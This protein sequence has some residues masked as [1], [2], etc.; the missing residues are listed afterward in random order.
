MIKP[1]I[2]VRAGSASM[3]RFGGTSRAYDASSNDSQELGGWHPSLS[4]VNDEVGGARDRVTARV[5]DL[6]RNDPSAFGGV[7][8]NV[9]ATVGTEMWVSSRVNWRALGLT[10]QQGAELSRQMEQRFTEWSSDPWFFCDVEGELDFGGLI[11]LA[12]THVAREDEAVAVIYGTEPSGLQKFGTQLLVMDPDQL[13]NPPSEPEQAYLRAGVET[14]RY[15]R[16]VAYWF[17]QQHP[18]ASIVDQRKMARWTRVARY[19]R[20]GRPQVVHYFGKRRAGLKRGISKLAAGLRDFK[21]LSR[22]NQAELNAQLLSAMLPLFIT[23]KNPAAIAEALAPAGDDNAQS[24]MDLRADYHEA[25][26]INFNG[27][28]IPALFDNES[29]EAVDTKRSAA[30]FSAFQAASLRRLAPL[31]GLTYEQ[32]SNDWA[33]VNYSSARAALIEIWRT[34]DANRKR[35]TRRFCTPIYQAVIWEAVVRGMI[36]LPPGAPDFVTNLA[37][38][39][40]CRWIGPGRGWVDPVKEATGAQMRTAAY[41][42]DLETEAAEQG[43]DVFENMENMARIMEEAKRLGV[44]VPG[45]PAPTGPA[46]QQDDTE[47]PPTRQRQRA[48]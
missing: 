42:T 20:T 2:R 25:S 8:K 37:H 36:T 21:Q 22:Y 48:A 3:A 16:P 24:N 19:T 46:A 47:E 32:L 35:F 34:I 39:T 10:Q 28:R 12:Y 13:C 4:E 23:S 43:E 27:V 26:N 11:E 15:G 44:P 17:Q 30:D 5:R 18:N 6:E 29:I 31:F 1:R 41:L 33:N 45:V 40:R 7:E 14:N 38:Y 9:N